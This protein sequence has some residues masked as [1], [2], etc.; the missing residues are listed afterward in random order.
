MDINKLRALSEQAQGKNEEHAARKRQEEEDE[1]VRSTEAWRRT[2]RARAEAAIA[3]LPNKLAAAAAT[4]AR[5]AFVYGTSVHGR[6]SNWT[7]KWKYDVPED[8]QIVF[9]HCKRVKLKPQ[10]VM[11][12]Q[13][14]MGSISLKVK[15]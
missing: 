11:T 3:D 15:W 12:K 6:E 2:L 1:K 10:W 5:E 8:G 7:S 13:A 9:D 4:G 14:L